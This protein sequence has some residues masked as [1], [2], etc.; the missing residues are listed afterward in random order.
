MPGNARI[1][2]DEVDRRRRAFHQPYHAAIADTLRRMAATGTVPAIVS[3]H[4]FTP[5]WKEVPRPWHVGLLWDNDPRLA[6][7]LLRALAAEPDLQPW[8]E[9]V[10][11]NEPYDGALPGD[12]IDTHATRNGLANVL[13]EVRQD[14]MADE[15]TAEAWGSRLARLLAPILRDPDIHRIE[16]HPARTGAR[17]RLAVG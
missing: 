8:A 4:S 13:I 12:T 9:K 2:D 16:F 10:G 5:F 15:A 6:L 11:D 14:L 17:R 1:G 7:P 3:M